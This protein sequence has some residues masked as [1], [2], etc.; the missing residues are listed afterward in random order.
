MYYFF[1]RNI[2][3]S[4]FFRADHLCGLVV[5]APGYWTRGPGSISGATRFFWEVVGLDRGPLSLVSTSKEL[6]ERKSSS[7]GLENR[8]YGRRDTSRWPR[9]TLYPQKLELT[10]LTSGGRSVSIVRSRTQAIFRDSVSE[11]YGQTH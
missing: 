2:L 3:C 10:S 1:Y 6:L 11:L 9:C 8:E 7:S 5:S 4:P